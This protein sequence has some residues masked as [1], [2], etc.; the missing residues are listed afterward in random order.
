MA[1]QYETSTVT[2]LTAINGNMFRLDCSWTGIAPKAGQ[3]FMLK[4][5]KSGVFLPRPISAAFWNSTSG[6]VSFLILRRGKGTIELGN[7]PVGESITLFGPLGNS[8]EDFIT[9][10]DAD[11][12]KPYALIGGGIGIAPLLSLPLQY[13]S[14]FDFYAGFRT[15]FETQHEQE[16]LFGDITFHVRKLVLAFEQQSAPLPAPNKKTTACQG[17]IPDSLNPA[18]YKAVFACGPEAMLTAV[19]EKCAAAQI[20]CYVS[21]ERRMACGV[22]ACLGCTV[23]A[24]GKNHRCCKDGPVFSGDFLK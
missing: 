3:F 18:E 17:R 19:A 24:N 8:W 21:L 6:T 10:Q 2:A 22:G 15:S 14:L 1:K 11:S 4:P 16:Q 12:G 5:Q 20:P 23:H 7:L 9:P 13:P